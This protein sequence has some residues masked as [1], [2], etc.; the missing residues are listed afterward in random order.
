MDRIQID[1]DEATG[2]FNLTGNIRMLYS[3]RRARLFLKDYLNANL[4]SKE[5]ILIPYDTDLADGKERTLAEIQEML[6]KYRIPEILSSTSQEVMEDYLDEKENFKSFSQ[7]AYEIWHNNVNREEFNEFTNVLKKELTNRRLYDLQLLAAFHLAFSQNACNFSVPGAGKT[8]VVYGAYAYLS[9]LTK[10]D[11]KYVNRLF[12]VGPL[13]SFGPWEDEY[14]ACF[15]EKADAKR[16][17]GGVSKDERIRHFLSPHSA[18]ITLISYPGIAS[19]VDDIITYLR[20]PDN[21]VMVV[22]DEAHK[23]K[24]TE[25][26]VWATS[27]LKI[28]KYCRSRVVLTGTPAPNGYH[29]IFNLYEFIWPEKEIIS[30]NFNLHHLREMSEDIEDA[31]IPSFVDAI[32]PYFIRISKEDLMKYMNL[33]IAIEN[34]PILVPMG[35]VQ[36]EIYDFIESDYAEYFRGVTKSQNDPISTLVRARF[37]RLMQA[38]T[39][40]SL[41]QRPLEEHLGLSGVDDTLFIDSTELVDKILQYQDSEVP[42]KYLEVN[43]IIKSILEKGEKVV[44]WGIF[45]QSIKRLQQ[46]LTSQEINSRLLI[47]EVPVETDQLD[48]SVETRES[49]IREFHSAKSSFN[50]IIANPFAVAESISL[51]KVCH[52]AIYFERNF[53]AA[54]FLQSKDRIHR[55][56]LNP[57]DKINYYYILSKHSVDET[58]HAKLNEKE[59][60]MKRIIES[61]EIPLINM[62]MTDWEIEGEDLKAFIQDY[63][64]RTS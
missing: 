59:Q 48:E 36:R 3:K 16:L 55:V 44:V 47:G 49:I 46:Y 40:P 53:N 35:P 19:Q 18:E 62:N 52:N 28:A 51:H 63:V 30:K 56:G 50:V 13:S 11:P 29:D 33:P 26:G 27:A 57:K 17:A 31:R 9:S 58:I 7:K 37:I 20:N 4:S 15:G 43:R 1:I 64:T 21:K 6:A 54:N 24:N 38:A 39:N 34:P 61:R 45:I 23:I 42:T 22:L 12:I 5:V 41:L 60:A 25:G 10:D 32:S 2:N 8:S 14:Y